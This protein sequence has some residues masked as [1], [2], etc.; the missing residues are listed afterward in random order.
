[1]KQI[2]SSE[3]RVS[4]RDGPKLEI[5]RSIPTDHCGKQTATVTSSSS[6][7]RSSANGSAETAVLATD[8]KLAGSSGNARNGYSTVSMSLPAE[9]SPPHTFRL[10]C[11]SHSGQKQNVTVTCDTVPH[12][13][14]AMTGTLSI[15]DCECGTIRWSR[16]SRGWVSQSE[17]SK[18]SCKTQGSRRD[19]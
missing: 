10:H 15:A 12:G 16:L 3:R 5:S 7:A 9:Q 13:R 1:M 11:R 17:S 4:C 2:G 8:A 18:R 19:C 14:N 6:I